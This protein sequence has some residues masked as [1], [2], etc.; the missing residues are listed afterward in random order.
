L[1]RSP[2]SITASCSGTCSQRAPAMLVNRVEI[3]ANRPPASG[4]ASV[5]HAVA[6][7]LL[8]VIRTGAPG[9]CH[10]RYRYIRVSSST[11]RPLGSNRAQAHVPHGLTDTDSRTKPDV[12]PR[13]ALRQDSAKTGHQ[14]HC[15]R[16]DCLRSER[17]LARPW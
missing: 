4:R 7:H 5:A 14:Q 10:R 8:R 15:P 2:T 13:R 1:V 12:A 11:L 16:C 9:F 6:R 3:G 17:R